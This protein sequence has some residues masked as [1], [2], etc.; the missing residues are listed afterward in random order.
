MKCLEENYEH[1]KGIINC[2]DGYKY[3]ELFKFLNNYNKPQNDDFESRI[4]RGD[5]LEKEEIK[6]LK[7]I[8]LGNIKCDNLK[9]R[10][11]GKKHERL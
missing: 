7:D 11:R 6:L 2:Y 8:Y 1:L 5:N 10:I 9:T 3:F 4:L